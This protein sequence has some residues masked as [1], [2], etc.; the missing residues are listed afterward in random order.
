VDFYSFNETKTV[1]TTAYNRR[2]NRKPCISIAALL[3]Q[4][5]IHFLGGL[6]RNTWSSFL[7]GLEKNEK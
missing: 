7:I 6:D 2:L 5:S 3:D 4:F 1:G